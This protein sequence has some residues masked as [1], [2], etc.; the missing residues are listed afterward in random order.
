MRLISKTGRSWVYGEVEP[1]VTVSSDTGPKPGSVARLV[2]VSN[3]GVRGIPA[4]LSVRHATSGLVGATTATVGPGPPMN[5]G[6]KSLGLG[7]SNRQ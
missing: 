3:C 1:V 7:R 4:W 5:A 2:A 6:V